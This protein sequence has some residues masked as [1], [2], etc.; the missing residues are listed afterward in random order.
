M[1]PAFCT[2]A[3]RLGLAL[4]ACSQHIGDQLLVIINWLDP[5][6][7]GSSIA[8]GTAASS[9]NGGD[10][11]PLSAPSV[12]S[13]SGCIGATN[14]SHVLRDGIHPCAKT[15]KTENPNTHT[16]P[17]PGSGSSRRL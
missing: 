2:P 6:G 7:L 8:S 1:R 5:S 10:C 13:A 12:Y 4:A 17:P 3:R 9:R 14:A 15:P 16:T 11:R